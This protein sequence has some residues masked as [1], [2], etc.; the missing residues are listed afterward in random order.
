MPPSLSSAEI[1]IE[2][3]AGIAPTEARVFVI[4]ITDSGMG[5]CLP[6]LSYTTT[7]NELSPSL[8]SGNSS[9]V[10]SFSSSLP[11]VQP[12]SLL[13]ASNMSSAFIFSEHR[14]RALFPA[15]LD[16][17]LNDSAEPILRS[18]FFDLRLW[19]S[20]D[21]SID[22]ANMLAPSATA[23]IGLISMSALTAS[24]DETFS[25]K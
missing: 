22:S 2:C 5:I 12:V 20:L 16:S 18:A 3:E 19:F 6:R 17:Y 14:T 7:L 23:V 24:S 21:Q 11:D 1:A 4:V 8:A 10:P 25:R 9:N 13:S 15:T